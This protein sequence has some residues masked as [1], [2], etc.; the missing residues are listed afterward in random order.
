MFARSTCSRNCRTH[1]ARGQN[2][3]SRKQAK[4]AAT[5][6]AVGHAM[7]MPLNPRLTKF[8]LD[9]AFDYHGSVLTVTI[10]TVTEVV[11]HI[12]HDQRCK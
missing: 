7:K 12:K 5:L 6:G 8:K 1:C 9:K 10:Y 3:T 2:G 4:A 11:A